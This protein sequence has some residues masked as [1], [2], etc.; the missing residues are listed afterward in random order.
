MNNL[1][2]KLSLTQHQLEHLI[3]ELNIH[4]ELYWM[5]FAQRF[6]LSVTTCR[7]LPIYN[8]LSKLVHIF[9]PNFSR[10][11]QVWLALYFTT[12]F[13]DG[14]ES[15]DFS[16]WTGI[17]GG[18]S[19]TIDNT[20]AHTGTYSMKQ[21]QAVGVVYKTLGSSYTK[22]YARFYVRFSTL[23]T[24]NYITLANYLSGG[25][26]K[27][28]VWYHQSVGWVLEV[29]GN[30]QY[31]NVMANANQWYCVE[32]LYDADADAHSLWVDGSLILSSTQAMSDAIDT[33]WLGDSAGGADA[34]VANFDCVVVA[35]T[36]IGPEAAAGGQQLFT[37][38]NEMGY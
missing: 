2:K 6:P 19:P 13:S 3:N 25:L 9:K 36:Y 38:I 22:I 7:S 29:G 4:N 15:G 1:R 31:N 20:V 21:T 16:A 12:I 37:L 30:L 33:F 35:D 28:S 11:L 24:S 10:G 34:V 32:I 26:S 17:A 18:T 8:L 14:F 5:N 27:A 23:P